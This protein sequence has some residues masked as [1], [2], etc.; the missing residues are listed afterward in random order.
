MKNLERRI[1]KLEQAA[2]CN[3][4]E[5]VPE[6]ERRRVIAELYAIGMARIVGR[7]LDRE[8]AK[9]MSDAELTAFIEEWKKNEKWI[10]WCKPTYTP[11]MQRWIEES[12]AR[13]EAAM[14]ITR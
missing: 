14:N 1:E 7:P 9:R 10:A 5:R 12:V 6:A 4:V 2:A 13:R 11:E 3:P 8:E